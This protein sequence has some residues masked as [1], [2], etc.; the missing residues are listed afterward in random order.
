MSPKEKKSTNKKP[1]SLGQHW[2]LIGTELRSKADI[3]NSNGK[4]ELPLEASYGNIKNTDKDMVLGVVNDS[5]QF[6]KEEE[7]LRANA[8]QDVWYRGIDNG[9][10]FMLTNK[11]SSKAL[12]AK[13][14]NSLTIEG[15]YLFLFIDLLQFLF[16]LLYCFFLSF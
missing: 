11:F 6:F 4:W 5:T 3:W 7:N 8:V 12:T 13:S 14:K 15:T 10:Y 1:I 9:G 16:D 2:Q